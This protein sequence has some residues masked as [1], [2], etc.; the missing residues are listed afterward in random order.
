MTLYHINGQKQKLV[1]LFMER[2][3]CRWTTYASKKEHLSVLITVHWPLK[4]VHVFELLR[5]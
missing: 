3:R 4:Y 5:L 2:Y 1:V